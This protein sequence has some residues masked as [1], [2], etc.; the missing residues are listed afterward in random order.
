MRYAKL[1]QRRLGPLFSRNVVSVCEKLSRLMVVGLP[2]YD[3][4]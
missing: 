4:T 3:S 1:S 2:G